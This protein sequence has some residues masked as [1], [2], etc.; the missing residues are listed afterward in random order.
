MQSID[1]E[2]SHIHEQFGVSPSTKSLHV[3]THCWAD[4][5]AIVED[6]KSNADNFNFLQ[7]WCFIIRVVL[8]HAAPAIDL[9][10]FQ[11]ATCI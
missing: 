11:P 10:H 8:H 4:L 1:T 2:C 6:V 9:C 7:S 3:R 5:L